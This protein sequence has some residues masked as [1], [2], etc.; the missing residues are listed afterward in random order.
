MHLVWLGRHQQRTDSGVV[1]GF[2][3]GALAALA[4]E[5]GYEASGGLL[6]EFVAAAEEGLI[7]AHNPDGD[8]IGGAG[9]E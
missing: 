1:L 6:W 9:G 7:M 4:R 5:L 3:M 2:D 8:E